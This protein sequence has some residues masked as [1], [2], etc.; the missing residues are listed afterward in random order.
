M[1]RRNTVL[2]IALL[3]GLT[4]SACGGKF[5]PTPDVRA[6]ETQV[7]AA[8]IIVAQ[9]ATVATDQQPGICSYAGSAADAL[10]QARE[11]LARVDVNDKAQLRRSASQLTAL[12][13]DFGQR[14][15]PAGANDLQI[16][17]TGA[18]VA[19]SQMLDA[20]V[21]GRD[22]QSEGSLHLSLLKS[23]TDEVSRIHRE[24]CSASGP[25]AAPTASRLP[26]LVP[27]VVDEP[28][29]TPQ[30][31]GSQSRTYVVAKG[32]TL[33]SI[34]RRYGLTVK[35]LQAANNITNPDRIYP[36]QTLAIP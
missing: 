34:A 35:Q 24:K 33:L 12:A 17:T 31:T 1:A 16:W 28:S 14:T 7:V 2:A 6:T 9:T 25:A 10:V 29:M 21:A 18:I 20:F 11:V 30:P 32:D 23:A 15:V 19:A 4:F 5:T 26:E 8:L 36:G 27:T 3:I 22:G 13:H